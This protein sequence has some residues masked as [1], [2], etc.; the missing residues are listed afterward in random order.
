MQRPSKAG[1]GKDRV[2]VVAGKRYPRMFGPI[3]FWILVCITGAIV[4]V[5]AD[6]ATTYTLDPCHRYRG[7]FPAISLVNLLPYL[8]LT[9][10]MTK[11]K[12]KAGISSSGIDLC[13]TVCVILANLAL[14]ILAYSRY[15]RPHVGPM[16]GVVHLYAAVLSA[17]VIPLAFGAQRFVNRIRR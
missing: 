8:T 14:N 11:G 3:W 15:Y 7:W 9:M 13:V 2:V 1:V 6:L 16:V 10:V 4:P 17:L 5:I 12:T